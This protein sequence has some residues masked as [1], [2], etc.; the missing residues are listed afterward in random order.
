M[1]SRLLNGPA[2][3]AGAA[4]REPL[5][6]RQAL[7]VVAA[8]AGIPL[9]TI[10][11]VRALAPKGELVTWQGEALGAWSTLSLWH[12]DKA[13]ARRTL[14]A[15]VGEVRRLEGVLSLYQEDSEI[16]RLNRDG[17]LAN[18]SAELV[19]LLEDARKMSLASAGAFD[20]TVQPLWTLYSD[21]FARNPD[22]KD[23]PPAA[24][25]AAADRLVDYRKVDVSRR[26]IAFAEKGMGVTLNSL[27]Q[28]AITDRVADLLRQE[29]FDHAF[30]DLG[31]IRALGGNPDGNPWRLGIEDPRDPTRV[32]RTVPLADQAVAISGGYGTRFDR[33]GRFHHIFDPKTGLS[34]Q[35][36]LDVAVMGRSAT[37]ANA[38]STALYVAGEEKAKAILAAYPGYTAEAT[39]AD[40]T[41]VAL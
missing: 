10:G 36:L 3:P 6:R 39:R 7:K 30:V 8:A 4:P 20:V 9:L 24:A 23:G 34:A 32:A 13:A 18:P 16:S 2:S 31:E 29:G 5:S 15:M 33:D 12:H 21:H 17:R 19:A 41:L 11:A 37:A 22:A 25:L 1:S 38:L 35:G 14:N 40:G 28:G 26:E 27:G